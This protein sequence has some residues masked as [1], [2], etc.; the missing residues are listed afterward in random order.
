MKIISAK[1]V[2]A[3]SKLSRAYIRSFGLSPEKNA[4]E[5]F[6]CISDLYTTPEVQSL[7]QYEQ[8]LQINRLDHIRSVSYISYLVC[9]KLGLNYREAAR[10]AILH[11]LF[12]YDWRDKYSHPRPHGYLHP[13]IALKNAQELCGEKLTRLEANTIK[14][15]MFPLTPIPPRYPEGLVVSMA[16]KYCASWELYLSLIP[17]GKRMLAALAGHSDPGKGPAAER[18]E[19]ETA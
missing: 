17:A 19:R 5:F 18:S 4:R 6:D 9:K 12:Y 1:G 14:R 13:G 3:I 10:G 8:H 2:S 15:H 7:Q 16:D 11:D